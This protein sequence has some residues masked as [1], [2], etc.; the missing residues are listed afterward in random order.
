M[1]E[2][3]AIEVQPRHV[4]PI[5]NKVGGV[6]M[7]V[8][9]MERSIN[10]YHKLFGMSDRSVSTEK[11]HA[12]S[13]DGGSGF[14]LDQ[15]GYD[16]GLSTEDR[17][18]LMFDSPDVGAAYKFVK[19]S[20]IEIV[21][22]IMHFPGMAF[23]TF[24]DPDG[25]LLMICG[26]PGSEE[27]KEDGLSIT[28]K[29]EI[30]YDAGG[31][32]LVVSEQ[33]HY[34]RITPYGLELTG[35]AHTETQYE[36][37][38]RIE[39]TVR[40]DKGALFLTYGPHGLVALNFGNSPDVQGNGT[41]DDLFIVSPKMN[42]H[43]TFHH[44]GSIPIGQWAHVAWTINERSIEIHVDGHLFHRQDGYFGNLVGQAGIAGVMGQ[45]TVKSFAVE[46]LS[47]QDSMCYLPI[48]SDAMNEDRLIADASCHAIVTGEGLWISCD[49]Q[50]GSAR[51]ANVYSVPFTIKTEIQ[52]YTRSV[53][54]YGGQSARIKWSS[55][56]D[57]CFTDPL[58]KEEIWVQ[59][60]AL[61]YSS[62][63]KIEWKMNADQ[64]SVTVDGKT[65]LERKGDYASCRFKLGIGAD[66]GSAVVVKSVHIS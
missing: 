51:T 59:D 22:D 38:L 53:V 56:G 47:E 28:D 40:I 48:T 13:M 2:N 6:F 8:S 7:H 64:T 9:N 43:F 11:V 17:A 60:A 14:V 66:V 12:I 19:E 52:S 61:P 55:E 29:Q 30:S 35:K 39:S 31:V 45:V 18:I 15:N 21:E 33:A 26:V 54:L 34:S 65:I 42:K 20:G 49:E 24:R 32:Q 50:W 36:T 16:S 62:F 10:W 23:F 5:R 41:G 25:N 4:H 1:K 46:T 27:G 37:P 58:T 3:R 63:A 57:L 44:K